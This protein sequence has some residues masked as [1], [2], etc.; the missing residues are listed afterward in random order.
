VRN[1]V[2]CGG[3]VMAF[4][5]LW[6]E[7]PSAALVVVGGVLAA[8]GAWSARQSVAVTTVQAETDDR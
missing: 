3:T 2:L 4:V 7:R 1:G 8:V 5:G 6:W